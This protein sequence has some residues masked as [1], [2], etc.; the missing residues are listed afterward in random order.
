MYG[1]DVKAKFSQFSR[2]SVFSHYCSLLPPTV[3]SERMLKNMTDCTKEWCFAI[4]TTV[5][6]EHF[7][8]GPARTYLISNSV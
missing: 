1:P 7:A 3:K 4:W 5:R 8:R 2:V 6:L